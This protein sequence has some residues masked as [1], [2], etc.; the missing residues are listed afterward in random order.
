MCFM[1]N[2]ASYESVHFDYF[3]MFY[4]KDKP[5]VDVQNEDV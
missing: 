2:I 1:Q 5:Q 4:I 3:V